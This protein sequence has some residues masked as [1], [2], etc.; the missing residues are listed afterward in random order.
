MLLEVPKSVEGTGPTLST[1]VEVG[2]IVESAQREG[3]ISL[4]EIARRMNA[5]RVR[6]STIRGSVDFLEQLGFV[7]KGSK[8]VLWTLNRD[9]KFWSTARR[10]RK[11]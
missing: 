11:L 1:L 5:K 10:A 6:H 9:R 3:P 2:R 4:A 7:M 8:G